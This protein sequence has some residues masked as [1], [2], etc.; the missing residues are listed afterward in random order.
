LRKSVLKSRRF[1]PKHYAL[2]IPAGMKE[3]LEKEY[4]M[5]ASSE[6]QR[7]MKVTKIHRVKFGQSLSYIARMYETS[8]KAIVKANSLENPNMLNKGQVLKIPTQI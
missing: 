3:K 7:H 6:K 8:V 5:I 2:K 1:I 4:S